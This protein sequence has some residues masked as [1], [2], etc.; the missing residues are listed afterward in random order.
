MK[1]VAI[2]YWSGTGNTEQMAQAVAEGARSAGAE[3]TLLTP[4]DFDSSQVSRFDAFAFGCPA[5]GNEVLEE[6]DFEPMFTGCTGALGF[7]PIALFGSY[8]WGDGEWMRSWERTCEDAGLNR[9]HDSVICCEAPDD[10]ALAA[11]RDLGAAL[12]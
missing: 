3:A 10:E 4:A 2:V 5:M 7:R 9:V 6:L 12:A 11:C 1:K 8:G